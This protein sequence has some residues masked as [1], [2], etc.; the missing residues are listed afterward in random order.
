MK[1]QSSFSWTTL[2]II[3]YMACMG[4][5]LSIVC[6]QVLTTTTLIL[7]ALGISF[8]PRNMYVTWGFLWGD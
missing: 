3:G 2:F 7:L 8:G 5:A 4:L 6:V 1:N